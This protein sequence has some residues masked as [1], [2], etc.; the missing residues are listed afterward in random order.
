MERIFSLLA[1]ARHGIDFQIPADYEGV[2]AAQDSSW[3]QD[4]VLATWYVGHIFNQTTEWLKFKTYLNVSKTI[5]D[6]ISC[7]NS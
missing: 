1:R 3:P 4:N 7:G 5:P 2:A 6:I